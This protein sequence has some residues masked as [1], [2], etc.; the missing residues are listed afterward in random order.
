MLNSISGNEE[1]HLPPLPLYW[2]LVEGPSC[3][4]IYMTALSQSAPGI[5]VPLTSCLQ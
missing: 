1:Y 3:M 2:K 5:S 4:S